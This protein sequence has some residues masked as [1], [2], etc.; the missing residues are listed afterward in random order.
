MS[1]HSELYIFRH[2]QTDW[3]RDEKWQGNT[4]IPLNDEGRLQA[5]QLA[6]K[7]NDLSLECVVTSHLSRAHETAQIV[8]GRLNIPVHVDPMLREIHLGKGE[9]LTTTQAK[10][11]FGEEL[12]LQHRSHLDESLEARYPGGE[13][14]REVLQRVKTAIDE[15]M[16]KNHY[17]KLAVST[18]G[19]VLRLLIISCL[20]QKVED[21]RIHNCAVYKF[22][23]DR[24]LRKLSF[25]DSLPE[26]KR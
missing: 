26:T 7:L 13:S 17:K 22:S 11:L 20:A 16:A 10:E 19:G 23:Y 4:D 5:N 21:F 25:S 8:A 14:R 2:G 1:K 18:H 24:A 15:F 9:G 3:N 12:L 6:S